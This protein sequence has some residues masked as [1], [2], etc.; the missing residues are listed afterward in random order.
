MVSNILISLLTG[1][2]AGLYSGIVVSRMSKFEEVRHQIKRIILNIDFIYSS[3]KPEII[4]KKDISDL[5]FLSCDFYALK[6]KNA[7]EE[8]SVLQSEINA[9]VASPPKEYEKMNNMYSEWQEKC[10]NLKPNYFI[11]FSLKPWA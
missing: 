8:V 9:V 6:H 7:G 3:D 4:V 2:V 10:R 1:I 5:L 11:I